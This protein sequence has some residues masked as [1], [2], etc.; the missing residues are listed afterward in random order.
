MNLRKINALVAEHIFEEPVYWP[1]GKNSHPWQN[2]YNK[3][4]TDTTGIEVVPSYSSDISA[5][6]E[7]TE[8]GGYEFK[9]NTNFNGEVLVACHHY[10][11]GGKFNIAE[12]IADTAPLALCL[13]ALKVNKITP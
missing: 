10:V 8:L 13:A 12:V 5:A 2:T 1:D 3:R 9:I 4:G 6:W 7:I 11:G